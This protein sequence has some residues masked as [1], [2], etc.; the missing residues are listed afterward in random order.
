VGIVVECPPSK[1]LSSKPSIAK[2]R[3]LERFKASKEYIILKVNYPN[4][5]SFCREPKLV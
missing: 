1:A 3:H 2:K 4:Y 5:R